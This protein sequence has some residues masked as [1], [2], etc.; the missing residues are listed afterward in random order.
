MSKTRRDSSACELEQRLRDIKNTNCRFRKALVER[1]AELQVLMRRLGPEA[2]SLLEG[3]RPGDTPA[4]PPPNNNANRLT[5]PLLRCPSATETTAPPS[6]TETSDMTSIVSLTSSQ[7]IVAP[8]QVTPGQKYVVYAISRIKIIYCQNRNLFKGSK[9]N[10][11]FILCRKQ[12]ISDTPPPEPVEVPVV[13][14]VT[15][16]TQSEDQPLQQTQ[17]PQQQPQ[18]QAQPPLSDAPVSA[19]IEQTVQIQPIEQVQDKV[20]SVSFGQHDA[21][22]LNGSATRHDSGNELERRSRTPQQSFVVSQS[23]LWDTAALAHN[24]IC[25]RP[26]RTCPMAVESSPGNRRHCTSTDSAQSP[27]QSPMH[28]SVSEKNRHR[29]HRHKT[30]QQP[31]QQP[32]SVQIQSIEMESNRCGGLSRNARTHHRSTPDVA[33][34]VPLSGSAAAIQGAQMQNTSVHAASSESELLDG[35]ILPIFRKLLTEREPRRGASGAAVG[36]SC[37]NISIKCDIVEYL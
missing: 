26:T 16:I 12:K 36:A 15:Q 32:Q 11:F 5:V 29:G 8:G 9:N 23:D 1:E 19:S 20:R 28:R 35:A 13:E 25:T 22:Q 30:K 10:S 37:P 24:K 27:A 21:R 6:A 34:M 17:Q 31:I 3:K 7:D 14:P 4:A 18:P 33:R 2:R